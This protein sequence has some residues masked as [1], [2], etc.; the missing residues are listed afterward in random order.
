MHPYSSTREHYEAHLKLIA[1]APNVRLVREAESIHRDEF[2]AFALATTTDD[3]TYIIGRQDHPLYNI[4][5]L[6]LCPVVAGAGYYDSVHLG[7]Q[8]GAA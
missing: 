6:G 4:Y 7:V 5:P 1:T 8:R 3:V 2:D